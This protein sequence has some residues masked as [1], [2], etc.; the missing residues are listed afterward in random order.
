MSFRGSTSNT[1]GET[2]DVYQSQELTREKFI[3][4]PGLVVGNSEMLWGW[5]II[6]P[7]LLGIPG[8]FGRPGLFV[9]LV[10]SFFSRTPLQDFLSKIS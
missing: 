9:F 1:K 3:S 7:F 10:L 2:F 5:D 6:P 8:F 4:L